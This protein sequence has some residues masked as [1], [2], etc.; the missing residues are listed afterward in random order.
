MKGKGILIDDNWELQIKPLHGADGKIISGLIVGNSTYQ[1]QAIIMVAH[2]GEIKEAPTV[3][4]GI[5]DIAL[6]EDYLKWR[7]RIRE[8]LEAEGMTVG[9][10]E[11]TGT[12]LKIDADYSS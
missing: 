7:H 3:G 4:I 11:F 12:N 2:P 10:I 8:Q 1:N 9:P 5:S 6:D